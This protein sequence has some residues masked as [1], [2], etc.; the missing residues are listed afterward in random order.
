MIL[1]A[2]CSIALV[3]DTHLKAYLM[4]FLKLSTNAAIVIVFTAFGLVTILAM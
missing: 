2:V 4:H 1:A 3:W